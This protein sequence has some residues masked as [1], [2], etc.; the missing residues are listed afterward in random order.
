MKNKQKTFIVLIPVDY[1]MSRKVCEEIENE[2]F[3]SVDTLL[4][5]V[6]TKLKQGGMEG[7]DEQVSNEILVYE[8]TNFMDEVNNQN[9]DELSNYFI[10]YVHIK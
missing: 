10:S 3:K 9:L 7:E 5:A 6:N 8:L 2:E 1:V 4:E